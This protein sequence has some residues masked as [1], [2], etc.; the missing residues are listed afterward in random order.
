MS[1]GGV[2]IYLGISF[3]PREELNT[4]DAVGGIWSWAKKSKQTP[5][6]ILSG[7]DCARKWIDIT[8]FTVVTSHATCS[9]LCRGLVGVPPYITL[10]GHLVASKVSPQI[11]QNQNGSTLPRNRQLDSGLPRNSSTRQALRPWWQPAWSWKTQTIK[12]SLVRNYL[13]G[14]EICDRKKDFRKIHLRTNE[15]PTFKALLHSERQ[16]FLK[17]LDVSIILPSCD[18]EAYCKFETE[19]DQ[20]SNNEA[21]TQAIEEL[22]G[23][24]KSWETDDHGYT[25]AVREI[26]SLSDP[27]SRSGRHWGRWNS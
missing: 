16:T 17:S 13:I 1:K 22:F 21:F 20:N 6:V 10:V 18:E 7:Q 2:V 26:Y 24:L 14:L 11:P 8:K 25:L 5:A 23:L 12:P 19:S 9:V 27:D 4:S 3:T 15:L